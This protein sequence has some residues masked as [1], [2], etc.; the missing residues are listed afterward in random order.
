VSITLQNGL[1]SLGA[2]VVTRFNYLELQSV[3]EV[4]Q[5]KLLGS[6]FASLCETTTVSTYH[7]CCFPGCHTILDT[8]CNHA[9]IIVYFLRSVTLYNGG[10]GVISVSGVCSPHYGTKFLRKEEC[11]FP[12]TCADCVLIKNFPTESCFPACDN[13]VCNFRFIVCLLSRMEFYL[14]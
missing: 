3:K 4:C 12:H 2:T 10:G 14:H 8:K 1:A 6:F 5:S 11:K 9:E 7:F 13:P